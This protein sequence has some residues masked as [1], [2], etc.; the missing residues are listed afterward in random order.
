MKKVTVSD[1]KDPI[2]QTP[3]FLARI[4]HADRNE[5]AVKPHEAR[6]TSILTPGCMSPYYPSQH[7]SLTQHSSDFPASVIDRHERSELE[8]WRVIHLPYPRETI[9]YSYFKWRWVDRW[10]IKL[11]RISLQ[12]KTVEKPGLSLNYD[13]LCQQLQFILNR[14]EAEGY[15]LTSI[16]PTHSGFYSVSAVQKRPHHQFLKTATPSHHLQGK[17]ALILVLKKKRTA[18]KSKTHSDGRD[19]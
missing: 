7:E 19:N 3:S 14:E 16:Y 17:E 5:G 11:P 15:K 1:S 13:L 18:K 4:F 6:Q 9:E 8:R 10:K 2:K 12:K